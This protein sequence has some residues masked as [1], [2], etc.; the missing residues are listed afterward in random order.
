M[1]LSAL[2]KSVTNHRLVLQILLPSTPLEA[3]RASDISP[4]PRFNLKPHLLEEHKKIRTPDKMRVAESGK[5][6]YQQITEFQTKL[7][8]SNIFHFGPLKRR[9]RRIFWAVTPFESQSDPDTELAVLYRNSA[10]DVLF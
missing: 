9:T 7:T 2:E 5:M 4:V 1:N 8:A 10:E 6:N 3:V